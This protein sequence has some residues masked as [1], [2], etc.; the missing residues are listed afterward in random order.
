MKGLSALNFILPVR[1][2]R[3]EHAL[4]TAKRFS[5]FQCKQI[6]LGEHEHGKYCGSARQ[7]GQLIWKG[8]SASGIY[9][10]IT[11]NI[12]GWHFYQL[13]WKSASPH[14]KE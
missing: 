8:A 14:G 6:A 7:Q 3:H 9:K 12:V 2:E 5:L 10:K 13:V 11:I 1:A 4:Q